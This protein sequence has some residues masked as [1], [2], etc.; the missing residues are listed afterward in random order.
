MYLIELETV[1]SL[2]GILST[3]LGIVFTAV[4][5]TVTVIL[6]IYTENKK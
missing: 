6:S 5:I 4:G 2:I 3:L 1:V